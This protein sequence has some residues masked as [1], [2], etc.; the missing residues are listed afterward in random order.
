MVCPRQCWLHANGINMEH[1]SDVV[2]DGKLLHET[3]YPQRS[4]KYSEMELSAQWKETKLNGKI[5]FYDSKQKN[6]HE[7]KRGIAVEEA[8][9]WQLRFYIWLFALNGI[10][11]VQGQ[12]EYPR[13]RKTTEV[14]LTVPDRAFLEESVLKIQHLVAQENCPAVINAKICKKCSYYELC[15]VDDP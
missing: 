1:T 13:L 5:D 10:E 4:G 14:F 11:G 9:A 2:Y 7:T 15:Y 12:I 6:I 3:S 8:H